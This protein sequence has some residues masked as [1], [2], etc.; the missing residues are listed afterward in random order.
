MEESGGDMDYA[1]FRE[2]HWFDI[3]DGCHWEN[4][5]SKSVYVGKH[6]QNALRKIENANFE[7]LHDVFGDAQWINKK[8][9]SDEKMLNLIEHLFKDGFEF[10]KCPPRH[11]GRGLRISH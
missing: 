5:R 6:L 11:Y 2:Q 7:Q 3:P 9:M 8:R 4:I 1:K 10:E